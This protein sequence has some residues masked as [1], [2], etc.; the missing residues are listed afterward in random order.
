LALPSKGNIWPEA[1]DLALKSL[2]SQITFQEHELTQKALLINK[3]QEQWK[4]L[5][6]DLC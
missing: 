1:L 4:V 3:E 2:Q 6:A 5:A